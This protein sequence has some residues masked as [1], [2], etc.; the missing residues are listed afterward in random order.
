MEPDYKSDRTGMCLQRK[1]QYEAAIGYKTMEVLDAKTK[2]LVG[3]ENYRKIS[4]ETRKWNT[5]DKIFYPWI[6]KVKIQIQNR[7]P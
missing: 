6:K 4:I 7:K 5:K 2:T 3:E 1:I